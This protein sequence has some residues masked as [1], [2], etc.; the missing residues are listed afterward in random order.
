[1]K[2]KELRQKLTCF[3]G[4]KPSA[5]PVSCYLDSEGQK[6][7]DI[8]NAFLVYAPVDTDSDSSDAQLVRAGVWNKNDCGTLFVE[9][10]T[11]SIPIARV[12]PKEQV[13]LAIGWITEKGEV[14][15]RR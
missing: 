2:L 10:P 12:N 13:D 1:M 6:L 4:L 5:Y 9:S 7:E 8:K 3:D 15:I 11:T 14:I